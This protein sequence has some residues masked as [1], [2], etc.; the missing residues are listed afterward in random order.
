ME[1]SG[2]KNI[3]LS[4]VCPTLMYIYKNGNVT[5]KEMLGLADKEKYDEA[6]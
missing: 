4:E 3:A 5:V 2:Y 6:L 1:D